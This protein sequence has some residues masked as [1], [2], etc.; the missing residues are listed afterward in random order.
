MQK[1]KRARSLW[2][3]SPAI[4]DYLKNYIPE[5]ENATL[6]MET[7]GNFWESSHTQKFQ[8]KRLLH[9]SANF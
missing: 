9:G 4:S 3:T 1:D 7:W 2:Q 8:K 5:V 6:L